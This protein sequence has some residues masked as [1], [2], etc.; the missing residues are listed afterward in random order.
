MVQQLP[1]GGSPPISP[2]D[3]DDM[4][5]ILFE[6]TAHKKYYFWKLSFVFAKTILRIAKPAYIVQIEFA[7]CFIRAG[8]IFT[9]S[10]AKPGFPIESTVT[11]KWGI[12]IESYLI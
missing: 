1:G 11:Q 7:P 4:K 8:I 2:R 10:R 6:T 9:P 3:S 5:V 12:L